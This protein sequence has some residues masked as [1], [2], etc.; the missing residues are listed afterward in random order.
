CPPQSEQM[1][2]F[3]ISREGVMGSPFQILPLARPS[4]FG[5][6][7]RCQ[8]YRKPW[9]VEAPGVAPGVATDCLVGCAPVDCLNRPQ[10]HEAPPLTW[11][12]PRISRLQIYL[13]RC[14]RD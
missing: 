5:L 6:H 10:K 3:G 8:P 12:A 9:V 13:L 1:P 4:W 11:A 7:G 2:S 14:A